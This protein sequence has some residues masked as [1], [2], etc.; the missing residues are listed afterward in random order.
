MFFKFKELRK[1]VFE[2]IIFFKGGDIFGY[3][4]SRYI[5]VLEIQ[6]RFGFVIN[7]LCDKR[8]DL[9]EKGEKEWLFFS[10]VGDMSMSIRE[11]EE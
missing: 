5:G 6:C 10:E 3:Q 2:R 7:Y 9:S 1:I 11:K 8:N 4:I